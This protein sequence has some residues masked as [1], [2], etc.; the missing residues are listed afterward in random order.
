MDMPTASAF[1]KLAVFGLFPG[2][3]V[4]GGSWQW[5][6]FCLR[7]NSFATLDTL[8]LIPSLLENL[9]HVKLS[10]L[11]SYHIYHKHLT[12]YNLR[13]NTI[14]SDSCRGDLHLSSEFFRNSKPQVI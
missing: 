11:K 13:R 1:R 10:S 14:A 8:D 3:L 12:I 9:T 7:V 5:Q 2:I 6:M 4:H